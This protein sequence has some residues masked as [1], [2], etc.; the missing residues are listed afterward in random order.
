MS[1]IPH[2]NLKGEIFLYPFYRWSNETSERLINLV[3]ITHEETFFFFFNDETFWPNS[4]SIACSDHCTLPC[5][6]LFSLGCVQW[7]VVTAWVIII[8]KSPKHTWNIDTV[9]TSV[10]LR[11]LQQNARRMNLKSSGYLW[12]EREGDFEMHFRG[13]L[14]VLDYFLIYSKLVLRLGFS[15]VHDFPRESSVSPDRPL[16]SSSITSGM[17]STARYLCLMMQAIGFL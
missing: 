16:F 12:R 11:Y 9:Q 8:E 4:D 6:S 10:K 5:K 17:L 7:F 15:L 14:V 13:I 2:N 3:K 1:L